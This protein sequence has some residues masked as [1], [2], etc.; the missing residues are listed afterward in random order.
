MFLTFEN[1]YYNKLQNPE[2]PCNAKFD[3]S[4]ITILKQNRIEMLWLIP[5]QSKIHFLS[6]ANT[7]LFPNKRKITFENKLYII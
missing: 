6:L 5:N 7:A 1:N 3:Q 4:Q 2:E